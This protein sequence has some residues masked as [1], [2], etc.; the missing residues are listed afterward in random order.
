MKTLIIGCMTVIIMA[1][2]CGGADP[3]PG[4]VATQ[5]PESAAA[6]TTA[7][8][9]GSGSERVDLDRESLI[10]L[11][12]AHFEIAEYVQ[13]AELFYQAIERDPEDTLA[14]WWLGRVDFADE[15]FQDAIQDH[16]EA[17]LVDPDFAA[18]YREQGRAY[19]NLFLFR[20]AI[21][22]FDAAI[23]LDP[24]DASAYVER[25]RAYL[26][27]GD[28]QFGIED[29][30]HAVRLDP[31]YGTAFFRRGEYYAS[32]EMYDRAIQ[33]L[34]ESVRLDPQPITY[35]EL[36]MLF[37]SLEEHDKAIQAYDAAIRIDPEY[38]LAYWNRGFAVAS[39]LPVWPDKTADWDRAC[40]LNSGFCPPEPV[41]EAALDAMKSA[42]YVHRSEFEGIPILA[43]DQVDPKALEVVFDR[44]ATMFMNA[45]P[46]ILPEFLERKIEIVIVAKD[47]ELITLPVYSYPEYEGLRAIATVAGS[48]IP[49][50]NLLK[51][52]SDAYK[53][54]ALTVDSPTTGMAPVI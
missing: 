37:E 53:L 36:G 39:K 2:G 24:V 6:T 42:Y 17:I 45:R 44:L 5:P 35:N 18:A 16:D 47:V 13:A 11:G 10:E 54:A 7:R 15:L 30:D 46:D 27:M 38:Y 23:R 3:G 43:G 50:E 49:E 21:E 8:Q 20:R 41:D 29:Y 9:T 22:D 26:F 19:S 52:E 12:T 25:G 34:N 31:L 4:P 33:D 51:L 1:V 32:L 14:W 40:Q 48:A 28:E